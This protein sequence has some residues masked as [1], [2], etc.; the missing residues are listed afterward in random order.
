M[1]HEAGYVFGD[2][3]PPNVVLSDGKALLVDSGIIEKDHDLR[4]L[5]HYFPIP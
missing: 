5:N 1:L 4:L 3:L 2:L